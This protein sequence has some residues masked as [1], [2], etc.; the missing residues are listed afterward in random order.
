MHPSR[1]DAS[2]RKRRSDCQLSA[3]LPQS[4]TSRQV[5]P[6]ASCCFQAKVKSAAGMGVVYQRGPR[7]DRLCFCQESACVLLGKPSRRAK[8]LGDAR[9]KSPQAR[10]LTTLKGTIYRVSL[11]HLTSTERKKRRRRRSDV[12]SLLQSSGSQ[13]QTNCFDKLTADPSPSSPRGKRGQ[14]ALVLHCAHGVRVRILS[15]VRYL[16]VA[17]AREF[18]ALWPDTNRWPARVGGVLVMEGSQRLLNGGRSWPITVLLSAPN[19][20]SFS[21]HITFPQSFHILQDGVETARAFYLAITLL[22]R[23]NTNRW[24]GGYRTGPSAGAQIHPH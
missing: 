11:N 4:T 9:E 10:R 2:C 14:T 16:R 18:D 20:R 7:Y 3:S 8:F 22:T 21:A 12:V 15:K 17:R 24:E 6:P 19:S 23:L 5:R 13:D 1:F